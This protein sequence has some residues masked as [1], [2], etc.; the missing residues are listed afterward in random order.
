MKR[1]D[2]NRKK[3]FRVWLAVLAG[4]LTVTTLLCACTKPK[5]PA[6]TE[7]ST[8][9]PSHETSKEPSESETNEMMPQETTKEPETTLETE[10]ISDASEETTA[11]EPTELSYTWSNPVSYDDSENVEH[12]RDP[13][14]LKVGD[15]WYMTGT[16][17]P[18]GMEADQADRTKGVPLYK[19]DD[20]LTWDFV[21]YIIETPLEAENKW[22][23]ERFWAAELFCHNGKYYV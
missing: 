8:T 11:T 3:Q 22:Y 23:S 6:V 16:L 15:V 17:P 7:A 4:L 13:F 10:T 9:V 1:S 2:L 18:Y 21:D 14:I 5:D 20:L 12:L 19:S